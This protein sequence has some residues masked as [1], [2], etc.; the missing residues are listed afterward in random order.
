VR[1]SPIR[2]DADLSLALAELSELLD[3]PAGTA[4]DARREVLSELVYGYEQRQHPVLPPKPVDAIRFRLEQLGLS[5]KALEP[6]LGGRGR[7]SE[8]L[9]G[10]RELSKEMIRRLHA[11]LGIPLES[12]LG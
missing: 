2:S 6:M 3:A 10:R 5:R 1:V 4:E 11:E 8:V 9:S 7:V 12:L